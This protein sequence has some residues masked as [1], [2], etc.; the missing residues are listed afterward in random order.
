MRVPAPT[1]SIAPAAL[2]CRRLPSNL[3][4]RL[5]GGGPLPSFVAVSIGHW[6]RRCWAFLVDTAHF[7]QGLATRDQPRRQFLF[8]GQTLG[9]PMRMLL[10]RPGHI[11]DEL[12][13]RG[14]W[15]AHVSRALAFFGKPGGTFVDVGA[16]IGFHALYVAHSCP[17]TK[18]VCFEPNPFVRAELA[19]NVAF[20]GVAGVEIRPFALGERPGSA[21]FHAQT[22]RAYNRGASSLLR[23]PNVGSRYQKLPVEVRVLDDELAG[24]R[25]DLL[26]ID[27]E[28]CEA[29]VLRGARKTICE[30]RPIVVFELES[31]F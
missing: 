24:R 23:N 13:R 27:T 29:A 1:I 28:G 22:A 3:D 15:E 31:R 30:H 7:V 21:D 25:V 26:K 11:E 8:V 2:L 18:V 12:L 4:V 5:A 20:D 14:V 17:G 19:R 16:N 9:T 10:T 6:L